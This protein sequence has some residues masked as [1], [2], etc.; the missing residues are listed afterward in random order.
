MELPLRKLPY[1]LLRT[2]FS[3]GARR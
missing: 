1:V 2:Y 3:R